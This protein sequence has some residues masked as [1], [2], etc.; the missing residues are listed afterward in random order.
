MFA[1]NVLIIFGYFIIAGGLVSVLL[2][3][4]LKV[5]REVVR[6]YQHIMYASSVIFYVT[7]FD[8]ATQ[9][10]ITAFIFLVLGFGALFIFERTP[11]YKRM[12]V[13]RKK[14]GGEVKQSVF[15][16]QSMLI[17]LFIIFWRWIDAKEIIV[18]AV[19]T[20]GIGDALAAVIG[21]KFG[22]NKIDIEGVDPKKT[23][24][25]SFALFIG[26]SVTV[27]FLVFF[28]IGHLWW[29]SIIF[30]LI[31][32]LA[33]TIVEAFSHNGLDT[34]TMPLSAAMIAYLLFVL[35]TSIGV[36]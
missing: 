16:A 14:K 19:A 6:K 1:L 22:K 34:L 4:V 33:S 5:N 2:K 15:Y 28:Y 8:N 31:I 23:F 30:A 26:V 36:I 27:G 21:K 9:A 3:S 24:E 25:G 7:L 35:F 32:G 11:Y 29:I 18:V 13:D 10:I 20:W 12:I 17:I